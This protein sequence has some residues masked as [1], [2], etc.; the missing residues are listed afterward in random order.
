MSK[1]WNISQQVKNQKEEMDTSVLTESEPMGGFMSYKEPVAT[2]RQASQQQKTFSVSQI[3][4]ILIFL[5][6][7]GLNAQ[8]FVLAKRYVVKIDAISVK[9]D[10]VGDSVS[11]QENKIAGLSRNLVSLSSKQAAF[12][13]EFVSTKDEVVALG[14]NKSNSKEINSL[15][16]S[17]ASIEEKLEAL[18]KSDEYQKEASQKLQDKSDKLIRQF[19]LYDMELK[20]LSE[21]STN[22]VLEY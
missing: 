13:N 15:K 17:M 11:S 20:S 21:Q 5:S 1:R 2:N 16:S 9:I 6:L 14:A 22:I 18:I 12:E 10:D 8:L 3:F 7:L 19:T 4:F